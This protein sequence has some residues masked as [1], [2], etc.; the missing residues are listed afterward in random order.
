MDSVAF[1]SKDRGPIDEG[2]SWSLFL[3]VGIEFA[4]KGREL[5]MSD[6]DLDL[7]KWASSRSCPMPRGR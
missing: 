5:I 3:E 7:E 1:S 2:V 6:D 4:F